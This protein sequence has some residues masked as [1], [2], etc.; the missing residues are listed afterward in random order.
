MDAASAQYVSRAGDKLHAAL[1]AF[2]VDVRGAVCAD[3]GCNIGGFTDCLLRHGARRVYAVDTGYGALAWTLRR[4]P[5]VTVLERTNA[6]HADP[7]EPV[8]IVT[9]DVG[10]TVQHRIVPAAFRWL[11]RDAA[12][13]AA[14]K[15]ISLLKPHYELAKLR[16]HTPSET[17][18]QDEARRVCLE[19]CQR[20]AQD[21]YPPTAV[22]Q[23]VLL[24]KGG[25]AEFLL[26]LDGARTGPAAVS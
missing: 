7:P 14:G 1:E 21:G 24:G 4:D 23:S 17:L 18:T 13:Q 9:I 15:I 22:M 25:N 19:V 2:G 16:R 12:G 20:L 6:L 3:L 11:K 5:R 10:W 26:L 8:D